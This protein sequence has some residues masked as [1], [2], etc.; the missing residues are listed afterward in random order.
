M[1][2]EQTGFFCLDGIDLKYYILVNNFASSKPLMFNDDKYVKRENRWKVEG[3]RDQISE[4]INI[5]EFCRD[6]TLFS[7]C[8]K[9]SRESKS[10][11]IVSNVLWSLLRNN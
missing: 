5:G 9:K 10:D 6:L 7:T 11:S 1:D 3:E 8:R 4:N 2:N